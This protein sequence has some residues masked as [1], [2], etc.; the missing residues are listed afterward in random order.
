MNKVLHYSEED[1]EVLFEA[2]TAFISETTKGE[3]KER[4]RR[5]LESLCGSTY[6]ILS[7][8]REILLEQ[9][10]EDIPISDKKLE[11]LALNVQQ[12]IIDVGDFERLVK[13]NHQRLYE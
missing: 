2:L 1:T 11:E 8:D 9:L 7:L 10:G 6:N 5:L 13:E 4:A 12:D 3:S